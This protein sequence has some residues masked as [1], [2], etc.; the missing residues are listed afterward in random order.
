VNDHVG[1]NRRDCIQA[2][3][4][5]CFATALP[6]R[7]A[8]PPSETKRIRLPRFTEEVSCA[9]PL[10]V[11]EP[12]L[13]AEGFEDLQYVD[14]DPADNLAALAAGQ[15]DM[16][17]G[18]PCGLALKLD[19]GQPLVVVGGIHSGCFELFG[20]R[21]V[22]NVRDLKGRRVGYADLGRKAF[23]AAILGHVGM[24]ASRDTRLVDTRGQDGVRLLAEGKLDAYLGFPPEP[25]QMRD[26]K[27]GLSIVNTTVDRPWSQYFCCMAVTHRSFVARNPVATKRALRA[28]LK[29][30]DL[31]AADPE[32]SVRTLIERG[33]LKNAKH[34]VQ[35]LREIPYRRW[36]DLD[37]ADSLRFYALRLHEVGAIKSN[38]KKLL[39]LGTDW[40]FVDQLKK[41]MKT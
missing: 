26:G 18:D 36:R 27:I 2:A 1:W 14:V 41:E 37:S 16:D 9:S 39:A 8:E 7:G 13:R 29:A 32:L 35:A 31:C 17:L 25:Q 23:L 30:A 33:Y 4:A 28:L 24:N 40:R 6:A 38:P 12:L 10:W 34:S 22:R 20:A 11:A 19:E 3:G 5:A 15:T 21:D